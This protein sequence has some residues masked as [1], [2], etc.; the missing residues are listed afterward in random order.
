[1]TRPTL[2][3]LSALLLCAAPGR[4]QSAS[5]PS[6]WTPVSAPAT[7]P[8]P[9]ASI[10][11]AI[12]RIDFD[13]LYDATGL[14]R[15]SGSLA[16]QL[17]D[18]PAFALQIERWESGGGGGVVWHG[19]LQGVP[20]SSVLLSRSGEALAGT[21]RWGTR[22]VQIG[23]AGGGLHRLSLI[24]ESSLPVCA[25]GA[26]QAVSTPTLP[27]IGGSTVAPRAG[28]PDIDVMVVYTTAAKNATGGVNA[29]ASK[30]NLAVSETNSGYTASG[31]SQQLV[32]VHT[33][34]M[35]GY[36]ESSFSTML[37]DLRGTN[38]G[39]MDQVHALRDQYAADCVSL[40]CQNGSYCG[41]AY[42]MTNPSVSFA[43]SAFSVVNYSCATGYYSFGHELGHNMGCAHDPGNA[44]SAAYSYSYGFRTS[45]SQYR[46]VL[47]YSP[48]TRVNRY[49]SPNVQY[50][51]YTM[52]TASQDNARS[53]DNTASFVSAWRL[54]GPVAPV[55]V[56]PVLWS[57]LTGYLTVQDCT[58]S[59]TVWLAF[60]AA[61]PGPTSTVFGTAALS[62]P[63]QPLGP[64]VADGSGNVLYSQVIPASASG[65]TVWLQAYDVGN[66]LFSNG[67]QA[68]IQ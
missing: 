33:E 66:A 8:A 51:G 3:A 29:M 42:L 46:T 59:G 6:L 12:V 14:P 65:S 48:G 9:A 44:G 15:S 4:S 64:Q 22:L 37:S 67:V 1:M 28:N 45:N 53:L 61:G 50:S 34:E 47:A 25:S 56:Q 49:S 27:G 60:S 68:A 40:I 11:D 26:A 20:E 2:L 58:P 10:R 31:V 18:L 36:V 39:K 21:V 5:A 57:G 7:V 52:G 35:V 24:D 62:N 13:L 16:L 43:S 41:I 54:G 63:I 55:F 23:Y 32:L 19:S 38:D 30:I 17:F